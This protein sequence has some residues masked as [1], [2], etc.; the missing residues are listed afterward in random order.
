MNLVKQK[1]EKMKDLQSKVLDYIDKEED[2]EENY[3]VLCNFI[4]EEKIHKNGQDLILLLRLLVYISNNHRRSNNFFQK[5]E[6]ILI[7]YKD[8]IIDYYDNIEIFDIFKSNKRLILFLLKEDMMIIDD[9]IFYAMNESYKKLKYPQYFTPEIKKYAKKKKKE[10]KKYSRILKTIPEDFNEKRLKGENNALLCEMIRNDSIEDFIIFVNQNNYSLNS[11]IHFSIYE[12]NAVLMN[13]QITLIEYAAFY[14]SLQIFKYL[15]YNHAQ[16]PPLICNFAVYSDNSELIKFLEENE[17][18]EKKVFYEIFIEAI[19][20][21][22]NDVAKYIQNNYDNIIS[23]RS[24]DIKMLSL[25]LKYH[26]FLF[27]PENAKDND[28]IIYL[29]KNDYQ[30]LAK[31]LLSTGDIDIE[32]IKILNIF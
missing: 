24:N 23:K 2:M 15:Y 3:E 21:H 8:E 20:C 10:G 18:K 25:S 31:L 28:I 7:E 27:F 22:N 29:F 5:I 9:Y 1:I 6:K 13:N 26:N 16:I 14:G 30:Q 12:T 17:I 19:I 4:N 32:K 11:L